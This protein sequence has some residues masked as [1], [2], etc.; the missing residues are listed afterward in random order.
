MAGRTSAGTALVA[1]AVA[2]LAAGCSESAQPLDDPRL[3]VRQLLSD[4][5]RALSAGDTEA[6]LQPVVGDARETEERIAAGAQTVGLEEFKAVLVDA[7]VDRE[8][9][10][11]TDAEVDLVYRYEDVPENNLFRARLEAEFAQREDH[12]VITEAAF[13]EPVPIWGGGPVAVTRSEHF[14]ALYRPE[15]AERHDPEQLV[16]LAE[17]AYA[18]LMPRME[19]EE[20]PRYVVVLAQ[21]SEELVEFA[22]PEDDP[23]PPA[24]AMVKYSG[25]GLVRRERAQNREMVV[26]IGAVLAD[27]P[28]RG[29]ERVQHHANFDRARE[30]FQHELGHLVLLPYTYAYTPA[31]V[32]EAG[33]MLLAEERRTDGWAAGLRSGEFDDMSFADLHEQDSLDLRHYDYANAAALYLVEQ[34]DEATFWEFY[35]S[36]RDADSTAEAGRLLDLLYG[37]DAEELDE[38]TMEWMREAVGV[39]A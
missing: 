11:V 13:D 29:G 5:A 27:R 18:R 12:W 16:A 33:A 1:V 6:Y 25:A 3:Q 9:G 34:E 8:S 10:T 35:R 31:W 38:R 23:P 28:V 32:I 7:G 26:N 15:L 39:G 24:L 17:E 37:F 21:D 2:L 20:Q 14:L 19:L 4:R 36:F 22:D 30:V